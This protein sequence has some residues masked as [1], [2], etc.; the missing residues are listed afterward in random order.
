[1]VVVRY[2]ISYFNLFIVTIHKIL[3]CFSLHLE[4]TLNLINCNSFLL[5]YVVFVLLFLISCLI[6]E[7]ENKCEINFN[8]TD[9]INSD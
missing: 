5:L 4:T 9:E 6:A 8:Y 7:S 2:P 1:M 3:Y